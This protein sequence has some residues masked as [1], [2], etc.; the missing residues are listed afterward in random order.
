VSYALLALLEQLPPAERTAF[1]LHDVFDV[2]FSQVAEIVGRTTG[3]VRQ[4]ASRARRHVAGHRPRHPASEGEHRRLVEAFARATAN[5]DFDSLLGILDPQVVFTADGGGLVTAA[6]KPL[7]GAERVA[8]AWIAITGRRGKGVAPLLVALNGGAGLIVDDALGR[9]VMAFAVDAG[10]ITRIDLVR[11]PA[12][13]SHV[14]VPD[15]TA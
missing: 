13:L 7:R 10:R 6:R 9:S 11:N 1:V 4:L 8:R 15:V 2:P 3:A 12:K 14:A 5:G